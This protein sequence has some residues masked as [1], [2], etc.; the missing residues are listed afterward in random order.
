MM[1]F[2]D[3]VKSTPGKVGESVWLEVGEREVCGRLD[4][5]SHCL[6]GRWGNILAPFPELEFVRSWTRQNWEVKGK[7]KIAVLGRGILLFDFELSHEAE[8]VLARGKRSIKENCLILDRWNPE[9][10]CSWKKSYAE[11]AWVRVI[12]LPLHFW[13]LEVF[14]RIGDGCGGFVAVDED[15]KS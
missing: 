8:R 15:T 4:Q 13:S 5:L 11:E 14:K 2:A 3:A 1:S 9:V 12:G 6:V 7:M 10:G